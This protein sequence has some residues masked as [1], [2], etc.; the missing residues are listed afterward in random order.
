MFLFAFQQGACKRN[1]SGGCHTKVGWKYAIYSILHEHTRGTNMMFLP[2]MFYPIFFFKELMP[3]RLKQFQILACYSPLL[4]GG[5][6]GELVNLLKDD[7]EIIKEGVL[8]VLA[9]AGGII[10]EQ[11]ASSSR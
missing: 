8:H 7:D 2:F 11:L 1:I 3:I 5:A 10:R 4:L 6:E 9:K